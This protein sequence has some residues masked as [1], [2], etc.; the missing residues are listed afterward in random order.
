MG[1]TY[2]TYIFQLSFATTATT[3]VSGAMAERTKLTAYILFSLVNTVV[4]SIPAH[5]IWS[6]IG[7]L[8]T[9][10]AIDV[11]GSSGVHLVGGTAGLVATI[12]L[13]PR[14][15]RYDGTQTKSEPGNMTNCVVGM[16]M[17]W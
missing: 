14:L 5:W 15:G 1:I 13:R 17:L 8:K 12:M 9:M 2:S 7:F 16:F 4:Y 6:D 10:G 3:I 11:A